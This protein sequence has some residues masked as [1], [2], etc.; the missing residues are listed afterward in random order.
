MGKYWDIDK[1]VTKKFWSASKVHNSRKICEAPFVLRE[2]KKF[3]LCVWVISKMTSHMYIF[4]LMHDNN[5]RVPLCPFWF[6]AAHH[7]CN[8]NEQPLDRLQLKSLA[9]SLLL[10]VSHTIF[11]FTLHK[12]QFIFKFLEMLV[13]QTGLKGYTSK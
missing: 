4:N 11:F 13:L 5:G 12:V 2:L 7:S 9:S 3:S 6:A 10:N 8:Y 1:I